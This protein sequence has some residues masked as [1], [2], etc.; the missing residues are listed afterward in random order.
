MGCDGGRE[1]R[2]SPA[3]ARWMGQLHAVMMNRRLFVL[4]G[5]LT[6]VLLSKGIAAEPEVKPGGKKLP[7]A[8][9]SLDFDGH[10]AFVILPEN[11]AKQVPW[12]W[13]APTLPRL[14][15]S[16]ENWMIEAAGAVSAP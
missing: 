15:G 12:V 9:E 10:E 3:S 5:V 6:G 11:P 1:M 8:G 7:V 4:L 13:Y 2:A 14:P 16:S